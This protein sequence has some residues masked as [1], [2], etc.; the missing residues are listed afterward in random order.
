[1]VQWLR[2]Q[3]GSPETR[4]L[5]LGL[6]LTCCVSYTR[7]LHPRSP[8][9]LFVQI[10]TKLFQVGTAS[11]SVCTV[12]TTMELQSQMKSLCGTILPIVY[13]IFFTSVFAVFPVLREN[14]GN[15]VNTE[16]MLFH[17]KETT[18]NK[19]CIQLS[20][21]STAKFLHVTTIPFITKS[22]IYQQGSNYIKRECVASSSAVC[23]FI[24]NQW[25]YNSKVTNIWLFLQIWYSV[26]PVLDQR[27]IVILINSFF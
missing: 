4:A 17:F 14:L 12:P 27:R 26:S 19:I 22:T 9:T 7:S 15:I 13:L 21:P 25:P 2:H 10:V 3:I 5:F 20:K 6:T 24:N 18:Q 16:E 1:M 23:S 11:Y 8:H